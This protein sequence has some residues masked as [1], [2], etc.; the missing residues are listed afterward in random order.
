MIAEVAPAGQQGARID[1]R[2]AVGGTVTEP[3][4]RQSRTLAQAAAI[5]LDPTERSELGSGRLLRT[6]GNARLVGSRERTLAQ[7][8]AV[9]PVA[10]LT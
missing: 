10:S 4:K 6:S 5:S 1:Q 8:T 3:F 7:P 2:Q 9:A